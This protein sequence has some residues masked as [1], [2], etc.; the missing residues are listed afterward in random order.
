MPLVSIV[1][2]ARRPLRGYQGLTG[3]SL[4]RIASP[5]SFGF[6]SA[7]AVCLTFNEDLF[8]GCYVRPG[9]A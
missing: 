2:L 9:R 3:N 8:A 7:V 6:A 5:A 4:V 1:T